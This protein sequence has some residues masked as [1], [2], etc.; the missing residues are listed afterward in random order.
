MPL[1]LAYGMNT[2]VAQ[3]AYR[4]PRAV[5]LGVAELPGY[6]LVFRGCADIRPNLSSGMV[7]VL[8]DITDDCLAALDVLEGYPDYY[9]RYE[10][11]VFHNDK[12]KTALVYK[13]NAGDIFPPNAGYLRMLFE[14]YSEH[15]ADVQ[16]IYDA[17]DE[18]ERAYA[19]L[20]RY[21]NV[22]YE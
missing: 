2:N 12:W 5:S 17:V 6:E 20:E 4:C 22:V 1:M 13:M 14:G 16:Q 19:L 8:W 9:T 18:S 21:D 7:G 3:M 10:V 15:G 11:P